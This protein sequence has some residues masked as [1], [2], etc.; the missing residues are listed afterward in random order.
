MFTRIQCHVFLTEM[1]M[2]LQP[3]ACLHVYT[4][5]LLCVRVLFCTLRRNFKKQSPP[6]IFVYVCVFSCLFIITSIVKRKERKKKTRLRCVCIYLR[7]GKMY[8]VI[9][10][11]ARERCRE[12]LGGVATRSETLFLPPSLAYPPD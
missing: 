1:Y 5:S 2:C 8:S 10:L 12:R 9:S 3:F 6:Y 11:R 7:C 4:A